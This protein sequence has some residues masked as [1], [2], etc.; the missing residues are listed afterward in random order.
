MLPAVAEFLELKPAPLTAVIGRAPD[1][2]PMPR[3]MAV[4]GTC[5]CAL[6]NMTGLFI[7]AGPKLFIPVFK[8]SFKLTILPGDY[9]SVDCY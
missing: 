4:P 1:A 9:Y 3:L 5:G 2:V 6:P 8:I 7:P